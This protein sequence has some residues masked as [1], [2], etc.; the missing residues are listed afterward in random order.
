MSRH[1]CP[2]CDAQITPPHFKRHLMKHDR[3]A[4]G[5]T[6]GIQRMREINCAW[7]DF[8]AARGEISGVEAAHLKDRA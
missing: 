7:L 4:R 1:R 8:L 5:H 2:L 3:E 6:N